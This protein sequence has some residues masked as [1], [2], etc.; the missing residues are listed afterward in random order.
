MS[1]GSGPARERRGRRPGGPD[2]RSGVLDAARYEFSE[3]GYDGA[4]V[5]AIAARAGVDAA[6]VHH[7]FGT[8]EQLFVAVM[9]VPLEPSWIVEQV[10]EADR[11]ELGQ[12]V[13][14]TFFQVW[15]DPLRRGPLF[16]MLRSAMTNEKAAALLRQFVTRTLLA[17]LSPMLSDAPDRELRTELMVSQLIGIGMLR[18]VVQAEP[19]ASASEEE[20][21]AMVA[22]VLQRYVD[23]TASDPT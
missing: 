1:S 6:L 3:R 15:G 9:E 13:A 22:P 4:T 10:A 8:K 18:Y 11:G 14:R 21:V 23:A 16:A 5:R 19:L 17:R 12:R 2:T 7:Y 20:I